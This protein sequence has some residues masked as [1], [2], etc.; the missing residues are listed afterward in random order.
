MRA[1]FHGRWAVRAALVVAGESDGTAWLEAVT[2]T[3]V[4]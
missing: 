1:R 4:A 3:E 2:D